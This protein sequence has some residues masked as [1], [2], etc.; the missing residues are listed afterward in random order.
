MSFG[1]RKSERVPTGDAGYWL[2]LARV[3]CANHSEYG[4]WNIRH[5]CC[6][7]PRWTSNQCVLTASMPCRWFQERVIPQ[8]KHKGK[9]LA[10]LW[11]RFCE[12]YRVTQGLPPRQTQDKQEAPRPVVIRLCDRC[13]NRFEPG[14]N[15]QRF[16]PSCGE[17]NRKTLS[18]T[19]SRRHR[20]RV[21]SDTLGTREPAPR[22]G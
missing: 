21:G 20:R 2:R 13:G 22:A 16:C 15:R 19:S 4:P 11:S 10:V 8:E 5:Y 6:L 14:S 18:A 7:E 3:D 12:E 1:K 9:G 17:L